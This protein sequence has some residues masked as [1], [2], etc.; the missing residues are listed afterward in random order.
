MPAGKV[1]EL[2]QQLEST[3]VE[4]D[5]ML[6]ELDDLRSE[7]YNLRKEVEKSKDEGKASSMAEDIGAKVGASKGDEVTLK[8]SE[9]EG[10]MRQLQQQDS[11]II[12]FQKENEKLV[13][14]MKAKEAAWSR[15]R[16]EIL[17]DRETLN[18]KANKFENQYAS[19][20][21]SQASLKDAADHLR[22][23]LD[24]E[25]LVRKLREELEEKVGRLKAEAD[26]NMEMKVEVDKLRKEKK[27][28]QL[29]S[30]GLSEEVLQQNEK[31]VSL[32]KALIRQERG[33]HKAEMD[34]LVAKLNWYIQNQEMVDRDAQILQDQQTKIAKLQAQLNSRG[35]VME[36]VLSSADDAENRQR[37]AG[38]NAETKRN[39]KKIRDLEAQVRDLEEALSRRHPDS[40]ANLIRAVGPSESVEVRNKGRE[41]EVRKLRKEVEDVKDEG[42][43][44]I[45]SLRQEYEKMKLG[46]EGQIK[47]LRKEVK[48]VPSSAQGLP[49]A[50]SSSA[51]DSETVE[52]LRTFYNKKIA[53][54]EKKFEA[55]LRAA[56]RGNVGQPV[57]PTPSRSGVTFERV[58]ELEQLVS[59]QKEMITM[60]ESTGAARASS[61]SL[62]QKDAESRLGVMEGRA[63]MAEKEVENLKVKLAASEARLE[64]TEKLS[65]E[66]S[67]ALSA[68]NVANARVG[69]AESLSSPIGASQDT[70]GSVAMTP[71]ASVTGAS[72]SLAPPPMSSAIHDA[73]MKKMQVEMEVKKRDYEHRIND[74]QKQLLESQG[75]LSTFQGQLFQQ[76]SEMQQKAREQET[77]LMQQTQRLELAAQSAQM[78]ASMLSNQVSALKAENLELSKRLTMVRQNPAVTQ[79]GGISQRIEELEMRGRKRE[80]QLEEVIRTA[81]EKTKEEARRI[82]A[83]HRE[84]IEEKESQIRYFKRELEEMMGS[85][86]RMA[87]KKGGVVVAAWT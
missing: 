70:L 72:I 30:E 86:R 1:K 6:V 85:W 38:G 3:R 63:R 23:T 82:E 79:F 43:R 68:V 14:G 40:I 12:G 8:K 33:Q 65:G 31:E 39:A 18:A 73:E 83:L 29:Q 42:E 19:V 35:S 21:A 56:K 62:R 36:G 84:E 27:D 54:A 32:L 41:A 46:M 16:S 80:S 10:Y 53:D 13:K 59:K 66:Q 25:A 76:Q 67:K 61:D 34:R 7:C 69:A 4:R 75:S 44:K 87:E 81:R 24:N 50:A 64:V 47:S 58:Q 28:F 9:L 48:A 22:S 49:P 77:H 57:A 55:Q 78:N 5:H 2:Q 17:K 74:L 26:R 52:R 60:M 20:S 71:A 15:E 45:R 11:L 51:A 37:S